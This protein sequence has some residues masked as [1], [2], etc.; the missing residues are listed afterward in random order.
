M[1]HLRRFD[2]RRETAAVDLVHGRGIHDVRLCLCQQLQIGLPG[3]RIPPEILMGSKLRR[4]DK[5]GHEREVTLRYGSLRT[6]LR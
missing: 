3:A 5:D 4:I 2:V 6:R 1:G